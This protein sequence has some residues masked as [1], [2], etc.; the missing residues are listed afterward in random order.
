MRK[1]AK[2]SRHEWDRGEGWSASVADWGRGIWEGKGLGE[3][4]HFQGGDAPLGTACSHSHSSLCAQDATGPSGGGWSSLSSSP[5]T[6][7]SSHPPEDLEGRGARGRA[8][9]QGHPLLPGVPAGPSPPPP[10]PGSCTPPVRPTLEPQH[11]PTHLCGTSAPP[12][13]AWAGC[14]AAPS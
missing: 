7:S 14:P 5:S 9:A 4:S 13:P 6:H 12:L 8:A 10:P 2:V 3:C 11:H 1:L